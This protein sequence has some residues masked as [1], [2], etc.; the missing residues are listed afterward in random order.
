M[1]QPLPEAVQ[2][3]VH[4]AGVVGKRRIGAVHL[5]QGAGFARD[6]LNRRILTQS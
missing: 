1:L 2:R 5:P 6:F 4:H 3:Y